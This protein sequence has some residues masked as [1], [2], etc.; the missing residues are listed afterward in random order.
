MDEHGGLD[1]EKLNKSQIILL[2]LLVS[3]VTS[4]ATGI[5]TV[6]LMDQA[7][8]AIAQTVNRVVERTVEKVMP[9][10]QTAAV[11]ETKTIVIKESDLIAQAIDQMRPSIVSLYSSDAADTRVFLGLGL[12]LT[13]S[14]NIV[15]DSKMLGDATDAEV[16][17]S[18][19]QH[20]KVSVTR[21]DA[22]NGFTYLLAATSTADGKPSLW[23]PA[24]LS[25]GKLSLGQTVFTVSGKTG[26]HVADGILSSLDTLV[27]TSISA[28]SITPGS[29]LIDTDGNVVGM[30]TGV[31]RDASATGFMTAAVISINAPKAPEKAADKPAPT[32][33]GATATQ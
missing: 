13:K 9:A 7:P 26:S 6:S 32:R 21:I 12:V 17:Q 8:P 2:T 29:P 33:A 20:I 4:I 28:D 16:V 5:I 23:T 25:S 14:G 15:I 11:G 18:G 3:F 10:A 24:S 1:I 31:A 27:D 22:D 19:G 30:S